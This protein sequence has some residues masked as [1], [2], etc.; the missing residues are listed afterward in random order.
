MSQFK[1][2]SGLLQP[3]KGDRFERDLFH[4]ILL[5]STRL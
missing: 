1:Y 4:V 5:Y 2:I 3:I